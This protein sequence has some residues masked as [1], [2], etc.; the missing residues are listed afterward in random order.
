MVMRMVSFATC[1]GNRPESPDGYSGTNRS[2]RLN[3]NNQQAYN[4]ITVSCEPT[5][6]NVVAFCI[7]FSLFEITILKMR[8]RLRG[9]KVLSGVSSARACREVTALKVI[10]ETSPEPLMGKQKERGQVEP[11]SVLKRQKGFKANSRPVVTPPWQP[12]PV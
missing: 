9:F 5:R 3:T 11:R 6:A 4:L 12:P 10:Q 2:L 1:P 7:V 8:E